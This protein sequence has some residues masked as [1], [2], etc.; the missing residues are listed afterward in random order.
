MSAPQ[1]AAQPTTSDEH[2]A[3]TALR[4]VDVVDDA[5]SQRCALVELHGLEALDACGGEGAEPCIEGVTVCAGVSVKP[6]SSARDS[7]ANRR[8]KMPGSC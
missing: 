4:A 1:D 5:A 3:D 8:Y 7:P 2:R 6:D